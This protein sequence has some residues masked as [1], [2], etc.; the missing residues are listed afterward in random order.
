MGKS[1]RRERA[2][3][4]ETRSF[5]IKLRA[6]GSET[7]KLVGYAAVFNQMTTLVRADSWYKGSPEIREIIEPG[8]FTKSI[9]Q[10]DQRA[11][12][13][14]NTDL[15]LGRRK[16][17]TLRLWEDEN[18]LGNEI[19]PP[20]TD[21][22]RD[23]VIAPIER[24]DVDQMSFGFRVIADTV[25]EDS[26]ANTITIRLKE[27]DLVEVSP[28]AIPAYDGT[29]IGLS[30]RSADRI[31]EFRQSRQAASGSGDEYD[32]SQADGP[33]QRDHA[34]DAPVNMSHLD[35][36]ELFLRLS[37]AERKRRYANTLREIRELKKVFNLNI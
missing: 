25:I 18:G 2:S 15:V 12:W 5:A 1:Y 31:E 3:T 35:E 34:G 33:D 20:D 6:E 17:G 29:S 8:A 9:G 4:M 11:V 7:K 13:N 22:I 21:M 28:V 32:H 24:G 14:H 10:S 16:N 30:A 27:I 23:M 26:K 37:L 19:T 36:Q